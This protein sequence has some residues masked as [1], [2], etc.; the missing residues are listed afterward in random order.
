MSA[1][2]NTIKLTTFDLTMAV[3]I[4]SEI[5]K[6]G[7]LE[8]GLL[9][10]DAAASLQIDQGLL[11]KYEC[12]TRIP[13]VEQVS[14]MANLYGIDDKSVILSLVIEVIEKELNKKSIPKQM[15]K[16]LLKCIKDVK[17]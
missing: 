9:L 16:Q 2:Q 12:G 17:I 10:R 13:S 7:R 14:V 6:S 5:L 8:K 11:C 4:L 3:N 1:I 15:T